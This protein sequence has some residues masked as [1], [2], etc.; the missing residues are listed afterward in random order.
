MNPV[1]TPAAPAETKKL[2]VIPVLP[3]EFDDFET[4][5]TRFRKGE[6]KDSEFT[7]YRLRRGIYGQ[8]QA[9]AQMVRVK[10][11]F[12]GLTA[13][14]LDALGRV[15]R[16]YAPLGKG[17][18][19]TRENV[20]FHFVPLDQATE[21][22]RLLGESGLTTREACGNT[23]RNVTGCPFAGVCPDQVFDTTPYAGAFAR[24]F[25]RK[26]LIQSLPRKFK[27]AFSSCAS[28]CVIA[29]IHDIG[30]IPVV[31]SQD[32][33]E[34]Q[35][36]RMLVGGGL[37]TMPKVAQELYSFVPVSD[38]LRV[39]EAI[40]RVFNATQELRKSKFKARLKF[41]VDWIGIDGLRERVEEELRQEWA[42]KPIDPAPY[43]WEDD[44]EADVPPLLPMS[45]S[46][47]NGGADLSAAERAG[48]EA[49]RAAS[50]RA[51][52]QAGYFA[53]E[54]QLP[55][56]DIT[57]DQFFALAGLSRRHA[58]GR[59]RTSFQQNIVLRW[60]READL[61]ALWRGLRE[62]GLAEA[63]AGTIADVVSCPGTDSCKLGITSS[64][65]LGKALRE[66]LGTLEASRDPLVRRLHIK[67][68]GCPNS[69]GQHH[70]ADIGFHGGT[71]K[72]EGK[73][74]PAY[75]VFLGGQYMGTGGRTKIGDRLRVR[76]PAKRVPEALAR[77]LDTYTGSRREEEEFGAF[78]RRAGA[79]PF[80]EAL[81]DLNQPGTFNDAPDLFVDWSRD[82]V[83]KLERGEGECM[84]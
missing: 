66:A 69:C 28:D 47:G 45:K 61:P 23:V 37:A 83:Y 57:A 81:K 34:V 4:E 10:I 30:F 8:R 68:S 82:A 12:G 39:S 58:R 63:G 80:E 48:F 17:H 54:I 74:L 25:V 2:G 5:A 41:L 40:L 11:P 72:S 21:V 76:I 52:R 33:K 71:L 56:G 32:G 43:L 38:Y 70:I 1:N 62:I 16:D 35:G 51:Q 27:V 49:W 14:Q 18:V 13:D 29:G 67:M 15:A 55:L 75:E 73:Q 84:A 64:M 50:V 36:F 3:E 77:I 20:Q 7:Q 6:I 46:N 42:Q 31:H 19:T 44:E 78:Y 59:A 79:A 53:A 60:V 65:G 24:Y 26:P 9:D 22:M